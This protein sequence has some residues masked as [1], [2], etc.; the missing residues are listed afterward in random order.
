MSTDIIAIEQMIEE[1]KRLI[2]TGLESIAKASVVYVKAIDE[3]PHNHKR[4]ADSCPLVPAS[5]WSGFEAVGRG[6]L[7]YRLLLNGGTANK[8]MR[9]LPR[10]QQ[11]SALDN[12]VELL[13]DDGDNLIVKVEN[14]T[15][16]QAKQVFAKDHIRSLGEQRAYIES[17]HAPT[18]KEYR[19]SYTIK[20]G[21]LHINAATTLTRKEVTRILMEMD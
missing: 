20:R 17:Q 6:W 7:D 9:K 10:S 12:G 16:K 3:N 8:I 18:P 21:V 19:P 14:L 13:L 1:F 4:F 11:T 2:Q 15:P 5:A